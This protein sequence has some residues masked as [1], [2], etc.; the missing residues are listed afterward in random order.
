MKINFIGTG[1][2]KTSLKRYHS[3]LLISSDN[4]NLLVDCGDGISRALLQQK[5]DF[6]SI[7][8]ILI[9]HLHADH[10]SGLA[11]LITQMK[12]LNRKNDLVIYVHSTLI[13]YLK[14]YLLHSYIFKEKL[15][16]NL[17][18]MPIEEE[19][20]I[21]VEDSFQ[22]YAKQN[23]H[24]DKYQSYDLS[25]SLSFKSFG[26][27]FKDKDS[28]VIYTGDVGSA[29]DLYLFNEK[30]DWFI[31]EISHINLSDLLIL[32]KNNLV[33]R[34]ILT[35]IDD[36]LEADIAKFLNSLNNEAKS[37]FFIAFDGYILQHNS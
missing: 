15:N 30:V 18:F 5:I 28:I 8:S 34:L 22:F 10:Y 16:F 20:E 19:K 23:S 9:S 4:H 13:S 29:Q 32:L 17:E 3:S 11:S 21:I 37:K 2:G 26:F 6:G 24:L 36:E 25:G 31:T 1:S 12:L 7:N 14:E 35:H 33:G 27:L